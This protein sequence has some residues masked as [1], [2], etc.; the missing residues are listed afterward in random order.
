MI[1]KLLVSLL[2]AMSLVSSNA[3]AAGNAPAPLTGVQTYAPVFYPGEMDLTW[4][5]NPDYSVTG[6]DVFLDHKQYA[7]VNKPAYFTSYIRFNLYNLAKGKHEI[8][9]VVHDKWGHH[10]APFTTTVWIQ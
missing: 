7:I 9:V 5:N 2:L 1:K 4:K 8:S 10:S 6:Y 3:F